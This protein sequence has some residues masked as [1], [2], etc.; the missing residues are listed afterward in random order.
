MKTEQMEACVAFGI[1]ESANSRIAALQR[2]LSLVERRKRELADWFLVDVSTAS[3][4]LKLTSFKPS[5]LMSKAI[6]TAEAFRSQ[7]DLRSG[8][9]GSSV[10]FPNRVS[11]GHN[12]SSDALGPNVQALAR[13]GANCNRTLRTKPLALAR[14]MPAK[15]LA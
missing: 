8:L 14:L 6:A 12:A 10:D 7:V 2:A 11:V 15:R 3:G 4:A 5:D 1:I 9:L 13:G